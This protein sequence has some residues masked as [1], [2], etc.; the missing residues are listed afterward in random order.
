MPF[1]FLCFQLVSTRIYRQEKRFWVKSFWE[2]F[3][4]ELICYK[5]NDEN[6]L[7]MKHIFLALNY[8]LAQNDYTYTFI[9]Q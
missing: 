1:I 4:K 8:H 2:F 7:G 6:V 3:L 5:R 9:Y